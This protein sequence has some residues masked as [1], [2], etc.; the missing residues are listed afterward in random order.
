MKVLD[1]K[2]YLPILLILCS[3]LRQEIKA[4]LFVSDKNYPSYGFSVVT[5]P[6]LYLVSD[7]TVEFVQNFN[8][9][10]EVLDYTDEYIIINEVLLPYKVNNI[11]Y[12]N[13]RTQ[14]MQR[15]VVL[16]LD[17]LESGGY[18]SSYSVKDNKNTLS[19]SI[20]Y[21]SIKTVLF[22]KNKRGEKL[23]NISHSIKMLDLNNYFPNDSNTLKPVIYKK[24]YD[25]FNYFRTRKKHY[26][27]TQI[28]RYYLLPI[29][30]I[31]I[32]DEN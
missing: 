25:H 26:I 19:I 32:I 30:F 16:G 22:E 10:N 4:P 17:C 12:I 28:G 5:T 18:I 23:T 2:L 31:P 11:V 15:A 1:V 24:K 8:N 20:G 7:S 9:A 27:I 13:L 14:T 29:Q 3:C 21:S 6:N